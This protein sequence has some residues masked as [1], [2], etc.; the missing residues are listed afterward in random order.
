MSE[1]R[2]TQAGA[3]APDAAETPAAATTPAAERSETTEA[4]VAA[5]VASAPAEDQAPAPARGVV[6]EEPA[7]AAGAPVEEAVPSD[8]EVLAALDRAGALPADAADGGSAPVVIATPAADIPVEAEALVVEEAVALPERAT[9]AVADELPSAGP[10]VAPIGADAGV[11]A[12]GPAV[13]QGQMLVSADHPMAALYMQTP[14]PPDLKGNRGAGVLISL[15]ATLGFAV[16]YAGVLALWLAP[17]YPPSTFLAHGLLPWL[18]SWAFAAA[19]VAF[20]VGMA[21][22]VLIVGR[23]GWWAYVLGGFL[24]ALLVWAAVIGALA[25]MG[26]P[27]ATGAELRQGLGQNPVG[28][29]QAIGFSVPAIAAAVVARE[30]SVWFGA[31]IGSR[32]RRVTRRNAEAIAEY[33][34]S[35]AEAQAKQP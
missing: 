29:I 21:I 2:D 25:L 22:L 8:T 31:W 6:A 32:G 14:M 7:V 27:D 34:K 20:F 16:V 17:D 5:E 12:A 23:A 33:E 24:V 4:A 15:L 26:S 19:A 11:V 18:T 9:I 3:P 30:A 35:L 13:P 1:E 10:A 28:L